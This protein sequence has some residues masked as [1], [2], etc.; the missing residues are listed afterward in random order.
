MISRRVA[1]P[2]RPPDLGRYITATPCDVLPHHARR[3]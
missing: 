3:R 2:T 1:R